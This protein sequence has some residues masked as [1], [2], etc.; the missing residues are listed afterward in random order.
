MVYIHQNVLWLMKFKMGGA[1]GKYGERRGACRLLMRKS[2]K[3][4]NMEDIGVD[5]SVILTGIFK[6]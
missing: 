1:C 4:E 6:K 5:G 3:S 2:E